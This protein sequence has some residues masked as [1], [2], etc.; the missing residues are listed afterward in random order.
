MYHGIDTL[1]G[2]FEALASG[3]SLDFLLE[4]SSHSMVPSLQHRPPSIANPKQ[5]QV[6]N[7]HNS[8]HQYAIPY[9]L[10]EIML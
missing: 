10:H 2:I 3:H 4:S 5:K 1:V 8:I 6:K 7:K 9:D